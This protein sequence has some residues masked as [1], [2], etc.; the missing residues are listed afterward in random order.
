VGWVAGL[1]LVIGVAVVGQAPPPEPAPRP[2]AATTTSPSSVVVSTDTGP[3]E[4]PEMVRFAAALPP[5]VVLDRPLVTTDGDRST[6]RVRGVLTRGTGPLQII[7]GTGA[8]GG[9]LAALATTAIGPLTTPSGSRPQAFVAR[10]ELP[11]SVVT[12]GLRIQVVVHSWDGWPL[13]TEE[14]VVGADP[15]G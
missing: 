1:A 4:P 15:G 9:P 14:Q 6:I 7:V 8:D 3:T 13:E 12:D 11:A 2:L 5:R 10:L